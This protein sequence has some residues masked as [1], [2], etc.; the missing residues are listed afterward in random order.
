M[1][2]VLDTVELV[3][4]RAV[5][6]GVA[7]E[8]NI[9]GFEELVAA[10]EQRLGCLRTRVDRGLTVEDDDAVGKVGGHDEIVLDDKRCFLRVEDEPNISR[11][12]NRRKRG[13]SKDK[14]LDNL[15][16]DDT[17][18]GIQEATYQRHRQ[19]SHTMRLHRA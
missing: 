17:L 18:L 6:A 9:K 14:P 10:S 13:R 11:S 4:T 15:T 3:D 7:A 12:V 2:R 16:C 5:G 1:L 8:G 19:R